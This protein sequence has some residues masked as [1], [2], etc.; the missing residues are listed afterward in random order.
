MSIISYVKIALV[1]TSQVLE[2]VEAFV[3][4]GTLKTALADVDAAIKVALGILA[5]MHAE[6]AA[7]ARAAH[8][9]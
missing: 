9:G 4:A 5:P 1:G 2:T 6:E 8:G 7:A 3:P